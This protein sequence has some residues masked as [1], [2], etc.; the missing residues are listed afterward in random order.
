[1]PGRTGN[2]NDPAYR[3]ALIA[4]WGSQ[5]GANPSVKNDPNYWRTAAPKFN[6]DV[7]E[8][9]RRMMLAEGAPEGG[10]A[11]GGGGGSNGLDPSIADFFRT[12]T[13]NLAAQQARDAEIRAI[14]RQRLALAQQPI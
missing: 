3:D 13:A 6:G 12:Q 14:I 4:Y 5:P 7:N 9:I 1:D 10:V 8:F 11:P 2:L